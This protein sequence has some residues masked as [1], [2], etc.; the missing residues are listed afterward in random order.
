MLFPCPER[1]PPHPALKSFIKFLLNLQNLVIGL[2]ST[3]QKEPLYPLPSSL[4][5][6]HLLLA[7]VT[8]YHIFV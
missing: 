4:K 3:P 6:L 1:L 7:V 8:S 5:L 2:M